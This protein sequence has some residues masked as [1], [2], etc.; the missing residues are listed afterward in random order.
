MAFKIKIFTLFPEMFD[1]LNTSILGRALDKQLWEYELIQIRD[2]AKDKHKSVDDVPYGG[3]NGMIMKPEIIADAIDKNCS[4]DTKLYYMSPRGEV[5]KQEKCKE[6]IQNEEI[7]IIC[8]RYE[9]L[10]QRIID[11]YKIEELSI[12]DYVLTGGEL[13]AMVMIDACIR[14]IKGVIQE[15]SL[16]NESFCE[17]LL[18][19]N[20]YTM[21]ANWRKMEVPEV[22]R[23]GHHKN[24]EKWKKEESLRIT[25][26]K[27]PDLL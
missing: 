19:H 8:G 4:A 3:G 1:Y 18:E 23:S 20:L 17:G 21:P 5:F 7:A 26:E 12:G 24:I 2:Y 27:R 11:Y 6:I 22:L 14:N 9:G 10:D 13:P 25:K 16:N 15:G